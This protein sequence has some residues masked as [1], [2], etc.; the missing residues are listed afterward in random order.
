MWNGENRKLS[1]RF[2]TLRNDLSATERVG[3]TDKSNVLYFSCLMCPYAAGLRTKKPTKNRN[4]RV[5]NGEI[6]P[7]NLYAHRDRAREMRIRGNKKYRVF[8]YY[9]RTSK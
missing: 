2:Y 1:T 9:K 6:C 8:L 5:R 7:F 4:A 3:F